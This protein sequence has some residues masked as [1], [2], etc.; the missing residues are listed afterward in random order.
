MRV[1]LA[2]KFTDTCKKEWHNLCC[3]G[4]KKATGVTNSFY[5]QCNGMKNDDVSVKFNQD[6]IHILIL[7]NSINFVL[8]SV[9]LFHFMIIQPDMV[10]ISYPLNYR[11]LPIIFS[12]FKLKDFISLSEIFNVSTDLEKRFRIGYMQMMTSTILS[13]YCKFCEIGVT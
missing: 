3:F 9:I 13:R 7:E 5:Q 6:Q 4:P 11:F 8:H 1:L 2:R 10:I 12:K